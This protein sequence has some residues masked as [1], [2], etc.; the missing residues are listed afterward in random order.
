MTVSDGEALA[1]RRRAWLL[2]A[3]SILMLAVAAKVPP[4]PQ[5]PA[6]HD[7]AD[8]R[9]VLGVPNFLNVASN[10]PFLLVGALGLAFL[11]RDRRT[12][13]GETFVSPDERQPYW[14]LFTG[15]GLTGVGSAYYHWRPD[16]AT[17]FWDRLPMAVGFMAL[18]ASVIGERISRRAGARLL[19][20]L[21]VVGAASTLYWQV[22][23]QRGTGD[24]RP[25]ALVQF[26]SLVLIPLILALFP[27]RY[28]GARDL[29]ASLGCYGLAMGFQP[30]FRSRASDFR[31]HPSEHHTLRKALGD[32]PRHESSFRCSG[33]SSGSNRWIRRPV[34]PSS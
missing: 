20:P 7:F 29:V 9:T 28:T 3:L 5:D 8:R 10:L 22:G 31:P 32:T 25:Y 13:G 11:A 34:L 6:Y 19:W 26:G 23:E 15:I 27:P 21:L 24:L 1:T 4:I 12:G 30:T 16:N 17:L 14:L 2:V 33:V 18:L